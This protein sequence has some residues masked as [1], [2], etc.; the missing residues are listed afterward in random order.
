VPWALLVA[1]GGILVCAFVRWQPFNVRF[2]LAGFV[3]LAPVVGA[4]LPRFLGRA[5]LASVVS[6]LLLTAGF[7]LAANETRPLIPRDRVLTLSREEAAFAA[8]PGRYPDY[9]FAAEA[10]RFS[11][12]RDVGFALSFLEPEYHLWSLLGGPPGPFRLRYVGPDSLVPLH[13]QGPGPCAVVTSEQA[14]PDAAL[15]YIPSSERRSQPDRSRLGS[16][17]LLVDPSTSG[18]HA[19]S[20]PPAEEAATLVE[21]IETGEAGAA[22]TALT[23]WSLRPG[24]VE[25][26]FSAEGASPGDVLYV[27]DDRGGRVEAPA[28]AGPVVYRSPVPG[29]RWLLVAGLRGRYRGARV[30]VATARFEP[31]AETWCAARVAGPVSPG[32]VATWFE[33][34]TVPR[35]LDLVSRWG[36]SLRLTA[37]LTPAREGGAA[38]SLVAEWL[39]GQQVFA[40]PGTLD[41]TVLTGSELLSLRLHARSEPVGVADLAVAMTDGGAPSPASAGASR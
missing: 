13:E 20:T 6:G 11:G 36:G 22:W 31:A 17:R 41:L 19:F 24:V 18:R 40:V 9:R 26:A 8:T 29:G 38:S 39:G 14:M 30:S 4:V 7:A 25:V 34:G 2:H 15:G 10:L 32:G 21:G 3:L 27:R 35:R 28:S 12:C 5:A 1:A 23:L 16:L 33:V 37:R